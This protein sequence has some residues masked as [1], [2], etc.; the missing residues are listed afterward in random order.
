MSAIAVDWSG[1]KKPTNK[2]RLAEADKGQLTCLEPLRSRNEAISEVL[3]HLRS[4]EKGIA[5]LD[6]GFSLPAVLG[7]ARKSKART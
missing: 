5:G 6:F 4:D 3:Q 1:A 2:I 7:A